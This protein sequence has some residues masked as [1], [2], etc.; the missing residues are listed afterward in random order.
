MWDIE[1]DKG[2]AT[3]FGSQSRT[4]TVPLYGS[5]DNTNLYTYIYLYIFPLLMYNTYIRP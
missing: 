2:D 5:N 3:A 1:Y 4:I